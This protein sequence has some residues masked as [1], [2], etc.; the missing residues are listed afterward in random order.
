MQA[1][2]DERIGSRQIPDEGGTRYDKMWVFGALGERGN[3]DP[4]APDLF[5]QVTQFRDGGSDRILS[6]GW[7]GQEQAECECE[8]QF[9][10]RFTQKEISELVRVAQRADVHTNRILDRITDQEEALGGARG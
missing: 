2:E 9:H 6:G 3:T 10:L 7:R 1:D 4:V 8:L 5:C